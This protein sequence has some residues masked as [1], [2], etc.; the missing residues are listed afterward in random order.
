ME[1]AAPFRHQHG[2]A[3]A[4]AV[5]PGEGYAVARN[6][7]RGDGKAGDR[8]KLFGQGVIGPR[9]VGHHAAE[10]GPKVLPRGRKRG[11]LSVGPFKG[12][13]FPG[14]VLKIIFPNLKVTLIDATSKKCEFLRL[15]INRLNLKD[16]E[17]I[18]TRTEEYSKNN[19]EI[20]DIVTA[21]AVAPLKHLL[22]Y[23]IPLVKVKGYFIPLKANIQD[24][25]I[26]ID[27][28][29]NKLNIKLIKKQEFNLPIEDSKRTILMYQKQ[30]PTNIIYPRKYQEI[31]KKEI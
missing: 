12:A 25:I 6:D 16:I 30:K 23:G 7:G 26:N 21:R 5:R 17:V 31:K 28:Y 11:C 2:A 15:V 29:Y 27:N 4:A 18:N 9:L 20:Y 3:H 24:E 19:R 14:L 13:G 8:P 10:P 22:E 1:A